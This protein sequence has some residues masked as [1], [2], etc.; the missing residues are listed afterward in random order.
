MGCR[1]DDEVEEN[2]DS[3]R[4]LIRTPRRGRERW[5]HEPTER[6]SR[7]ATGNY[8]LPAWLQPER[9]AEPRDPSIGEIDAAIIITHLFLSCVTRRSRAL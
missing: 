6:I 2:E 4:P 7:S 9:R 3:I 1:T 8:L 5:P